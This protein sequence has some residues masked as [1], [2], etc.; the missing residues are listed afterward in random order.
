MWASGSYGYLS[1]YLWWWI[2]ALSLLIHTGCFFRF[3]PKSRPGLR[4]LAGNVL[5]FATLLSLA[6]LVGETYV[7][8]LVVE[9][10]SYGASLVSKRWFQIYPTLNSL[11]CRDKEWAEG[12]QVG[13]RRIAFIGDSFTY[14]WGINDT[15]D[16]FTDIIQSRFDSKA[17]GKIEVMNVAWSGWGTKEHI[18]AVHDM[19][20]DYAVDEIVL[21]HLPNDI[22]T[23]L[24]VTPDFDP[25][26]P[27]KSHYINTEHSFL[28]NYLYH[29]AIAPYAR[30]AHSYWDWLATGYSDPTIWSRQEAQFD[31]IL[32]L[33]NTHHV[34]LRVALLPFLRTAGNKYDSARVQSLVRS[35]FEK[36]GI[37]IVDLLPVIAGLDATKLVVNSHDPHPNEAANRLFAD[38]IWKAF[39]DDRSIAKSEPRP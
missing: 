13:V 21:C 6:G 31:R 1:D 29:R 36:H 22:D 34:R 9:T 19:I 24:P 30:G 26:L 11:Y 2:A 37:Q 35:Y 14:G 28:L 5:V 17:P 27:P 7:R 33:C 8:F 38:A 32:E 10:D 12:R 4:L 39:F 23:L 3:F 25:K 18:N 20:Q 15:R 16:R